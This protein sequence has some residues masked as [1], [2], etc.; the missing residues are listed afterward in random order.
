MS[1]GMCLSMLSI[2]LFPVLW[3]QL[4]ATA[5]AH[6]ESSKLLQILTHDASV[7]IFDAH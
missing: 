1:A 4:G 3:V 2:S 6:R 5:T 7:G